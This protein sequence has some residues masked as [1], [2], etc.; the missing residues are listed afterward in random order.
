MKLSIAI[1][2]FALSGCTM[3]VMRPDVSPPTKE[4]KQFHADL[5]AEQNN[6]PCWESVKQSAGEAYD[7]A[8]E[9]Y[10]QVKESQQL[11]DAEERAKKTYRWLYN[12]AGDTWKS[13]SDAVEG[14]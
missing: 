3:H 4:E 9:K 8:Q 2:A 6:S 14:E 10:E 13:A 5:P 11:K 1:L 12:K 7:Y